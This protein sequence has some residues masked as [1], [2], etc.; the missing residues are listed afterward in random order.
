MEE[1][2]HQA[3]IEHGEQEAEKADNVCEKC[4]TVLTEENTCPKCGKHLDCTCEC[5]KVE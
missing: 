4:D 3:A 2:N 1:H 5:E